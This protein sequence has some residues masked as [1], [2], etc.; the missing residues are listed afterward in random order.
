MFGKI[1]RSSPPAVSGDTIFRAQGPLNLHPASKISFRLSFLPPRRTY[2]YL[3]SRTVVHNRCPAYPKVTGEARIRRREAGPPSPDTLPRNLCLVFRQASLISFAVSL[4]S[5]IQK[6]NTVLK[7]P[8]QSCLWWSFFRHGG[9]AAAEKI[10]GE[11][12]V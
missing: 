7:K 12:L 11:I 10:P 5:Q 4:Y 8:Y 2:S 3:T 1:R 6:N 9:F